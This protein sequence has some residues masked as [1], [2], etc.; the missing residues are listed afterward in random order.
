MNW[1][2]KIYASLLFENVYDL[3]ASKTAKPTVGNKLPAHILK[4]MAAAKAK[5]KTKKK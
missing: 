3:K 2:D 5:P 4:I 1:R